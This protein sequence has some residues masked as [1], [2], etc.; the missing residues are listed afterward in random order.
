MY[1]EHALMLDNKRVCNEI[2]LPF[3]DIEAIGLYRK[4]VRPIY[5][6][7]GDP[8]NLNCQSNTT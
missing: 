1:L 8:N 5:E 6:I 7:S 2:V 3:T 4:K